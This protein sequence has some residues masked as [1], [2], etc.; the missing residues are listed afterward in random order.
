MWGLYG[1]MNQGTIKWQIDNMS[2]DSPIIGFDITPILYGRGVSRY[3]SNII[4]ALRKKNAQVR[5]FGS[6][7]RANRSL[8][9]LARDF[10][11][12][13][14]VTQK[15]SI[16]SFPPSFLAR[17][18]YGVGRLHIESLMPKVEVFHA[19]E[20]LVPPSYTT[21]IVATIHD[22]APFKFP[23]MAHPSTREK[24]A[25]AYKRLKE[26]GS[27]VIA[28]SEQT[29]RDLIEMLEFDPN[30]IHVIYEAL[31]TENIVKK[32]DILSRPELEKL[33]GITK[34]YFL[35]VGTQEPRKNLERAYKAWKQYSKDYD[36][37]LIGASGTKEVKAQEGVKILGYLS[38]AQVAS[39]YTHAQ[40]LLYPSLYE[41]FGLPIL[42][43]FHY[44]CPVVTSN[45]SGM[46]ESGGDAATYVDPY[47]V[48]SIA[49]GIQETISYKNETARTKKM[50]AQLAKFS[51][52]KAA[53]ETLKVYK[54]AIRDRSR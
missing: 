13:I 32:D 29:K 43:A 50:K 30:K 18:W 28:V 3:T 8:K 31:P 49:S 20:E 11:K 51:W 4:R 52:E 23:Q 21:P 7:F 9:T 40:L 54:L 1:C 46:S 44:G 38:H 10:G 53:T 36:L 26:Y 33:Y 48:E 14:G 6:S 39:F 17:M 27:H 22:L 16:L 25:A 37:V 42:E 5:F 15:P 41:G 34:P 47:S 45:N 12:E 24:H 19:W 35:W 2:Q